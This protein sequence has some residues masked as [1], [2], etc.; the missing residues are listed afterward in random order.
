MYEILFGYILLLSDFK[1]LGIKINCGWISLCLGLR[2]LLSDQSAFECIL[3]SWHTFGDNIAHV[4]FCY[5]TVQEYLFCYQTKS[6]SPSATKTKS[7]LNAHARQIVQIGNHDLQ[8]LACDRQ[9]CHHRYEA[10]VQLS[11][12]ER[13]LGRFLINNLTLS[14]KTGLRRQGKSVSM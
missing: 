9:R 12:Y 5:S 13:S 6:F 2:R 8:Q 4:Y 1:A 3:Q 7:L 14:E 11:P 10:A